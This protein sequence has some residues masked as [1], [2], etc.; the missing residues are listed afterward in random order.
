MKIGLALGG[1][2]GDTLESLVDKI[3]QTEKAGFHSAWLANIFS[4]DALTVLAMAGPRTSR[5]ELGTAVV[6]TYPRHPHAL[7]QQAATVNAATG[8]RL[9]LGLGRSHQMVI[10]NMFG[11]AYDKPIAHMRD[12]VTVVRDLI[13]NGS[14]AVDGKAYKVNAPL[15]VEGGKPF[16]ILIGALMPKMLE[17]CGTLCDGT[18]TWMS[19]AVHLEKNIV[20]VMKAAAEK[21]GRA[22]PRVVCS[23]PVCVTDDVDAARAIAAKAFQIYGLLPV[24]RACLDQEGC[25]GPEDIALIGDE[26]TVRAGLGRISAAGATDFYGALFPDESGSASIDRSTRFLAS[27]GGNIG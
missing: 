26:E 4:L 13:N 15:T 1:G 20:P 11:M 17:L 24:Y 18:L 16:P 22:M 14:C 23:L 3:V 21:A 6:P 5:I 12:Y 19:G 2:D 8:G 9:A 7:A 25:A 10:E 27:L